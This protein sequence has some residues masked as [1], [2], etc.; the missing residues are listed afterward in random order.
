MSKTDIVIIE[1]DRPRELR[2][3]HKACKLINKMLRKP[4]EKIDL[5]ELD[6]EMKEKILYC[7]LLAD[8]K[9]LKMDDMEDI[10]DNISQG[11]LLLKLV[12]AIELAYGFDG[13]KVKE[14]ME[15]DDEGNKKK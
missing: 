13:E 7:G 15:I 4:L 6:P 3:G 10:L 11:E 8:D 2:F 5:A 9:D 14:A 1:L 12:K